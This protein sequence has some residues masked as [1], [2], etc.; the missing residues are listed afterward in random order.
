VTSSNK[1]FQNSIIDKSIHVLLFSLLHLQYII[2]EFHKFLR[3]KLRIKYNKLANIAKFT[4]LKSILS[5]NRKVPSILIPRFSFHPWRLSAH[6]ETSLLYSNDFNAGNSSN[7][8]KKTSPVCPF[9]CRR[10]G[11]KKGARFFSSK[12]IKR[13][14]ILLR[15]PCSDIW[16]GWIYPQQH[17][18]Y[19]SHAP[20]YGGGAWHQGTSLYYF[21]R[22]MGWIY[23]SRGG[24]DSGRI[25]APRG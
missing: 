24:L 6:M 14:H 22:G 3:M 21:I 20:G 4:T 17:T 12:K 8:E 1:K 16:T 5:S 7:L 23:H 18:F 13:W 15:V 19:V 11:P 25:I 2:D 10:I 9:N